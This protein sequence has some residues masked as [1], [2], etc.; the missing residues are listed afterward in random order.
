MFGSIGRRA[1]IGA[2]YACGI[3]A[4][5]CDAEAS[6]AYFHF[7]SRNSLNCSGGEQFLN[8]QNVGSR[9]YFQLDAVIAIRNSY[10]CANTWSEANRSSGQR[11][12]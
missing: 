6:R 9:L 12:S 11:G 1:N 10:S 2:E 8:I 7:A 4:E 5:S 3:P